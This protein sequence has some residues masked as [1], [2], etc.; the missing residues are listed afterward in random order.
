M[1]IDTHTSLAKLAID[2]VQT[3]LPEWE[4]SGLMEKAIM[5]GAIEADFNP[6][7]FVKPHYYT[8]SGDTVLTSIDNLLENRLKLRPVEIGTIVHYLQD[9]CCYAH[10][11]ENAGDLQ[12]HIEYEKK[13]K[14]GFYKNVF[15]LTMLKLPMP[16]KEDSV[17]FIK[18]LIEK[19]RKEVP[20][21]EN[22]LLYSLNALTVFLFNA[23]QSVFEYEFVGSIIS[24][25]G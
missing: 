24:V 2:K 22:D 15:E 21:V 23:V 17:E 14:A 19:Y 1:K 9:F 16:K 6:I 3:M 10:F 25:G 13:L 12:K 8:R 4:I 5:F 20:S 7:R 11:G 18:Y